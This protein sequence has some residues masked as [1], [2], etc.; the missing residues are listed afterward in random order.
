MELAVFTSSIVPAGIVAALKD[1]TAK[2]AQHTAISP[3][4]LFRIIFCFEKL[5][6]ELCAEGKLCWILSWGFVRRLIRGD[7]RNLHR[8]INY[9][10]YHSRH[11]ATDKVRD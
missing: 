10:E 4:S 5:N 2:Q 7:W 3:I 6:R 1:E 9:L 8:R 11:S